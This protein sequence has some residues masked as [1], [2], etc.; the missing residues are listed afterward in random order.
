MQGIDRVRAQ[1]GCGIALR[2]GHFVQRRLDQRAAGEHLQFIQQ[3]ARCVRTLRAAGG[4]RRLD[5]NRTGVDLRPRAGQVNRRSRV[6][7]VKADG[8]QRQKRHC[9]NQKFAPVG[10]LGGR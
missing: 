3:R 4:H 2:I 10:A 7:Q 9:K 8:S 5:L 1:A 6:A